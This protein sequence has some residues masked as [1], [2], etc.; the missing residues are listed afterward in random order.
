MNAARMD[1]LYPIREQIENYF[2]EKSYG[3]SI[4][5]I[6]Q[7]GFIGDMTLNKEKNFTVYEC[8]F[9]ER[10]HFLT[11]LQHHNLGNLKNH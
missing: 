7:S 2:I 4:D 11:S 5:K 10:H 1:E 9:A 6:P 3:T 8:D